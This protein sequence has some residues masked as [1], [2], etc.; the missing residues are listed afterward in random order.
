M[1]ALPGQTILLMGNEY[2]SINYPDQH[3]PFRQDSSFLYYFGIDRPGMWGIL[4]GNSGKSYLVGE[5]VSIDHIVWMGPQPTMAEFQT[6][7]GVEE[8]CGYA[9]GQ[10]KLLEQGKVHFLPSYRPENTRKISEWLSL[11]LAE[12][13]TQYS[14]E[15][16][17]AIVNQRSYK[18]AEELAEMH[19]AVDLTREMH[20]AAARAI[21]VGKRES[22][23]MAE[24]YA[25]AL[26]SD[27]TPSYGIICSVRGEVLHN[28]HYHNELIEGQ[29]LLV[30]AGGESPLHYAGDIT[31]TFPVSG[32]FTSQQLEIY[33]LVEQALRKS[34]EMLKPGISYREVHLAAAELMT[35]GLIDLGLMKGNAAEAVAAGAHALFF[36]HG[37]GHM[38][39]LDVHDMEDFGEDH[40]GYDAE[41]Q[42]SSQF[43]LRSLRLGRKLEAGFCLTVE[44]G[45]YFIPDLIDKWKAEGQHASYINFDALDAYRNFGGIRLEDDYII[46]QTGA[47]MIGTPIPLSPAE[48]E[49]AM[50]N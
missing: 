26:K 48:V 11:S 28:V 21:S 32:T 29:L 50:R 25:T 3:Y 35:Q 44:P 23:V 20:L 5:D 9:E 41:Y 33:T 8:I 24:I 30:D 18:T 13:E 22:D 10:K 31:R 49:E 15:L 4:D 37:L 39:G 1:Q 6:A 47:E 36:P 38:I 17:Q 34:G 14:L 2:S 16:I 42:R 12:V 40:V 19:L 43:G 7:C 27:S 46:T 45:I